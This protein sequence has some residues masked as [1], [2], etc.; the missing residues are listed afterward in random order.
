MGAAADVKGIKLVTAVLDGASVNEIRAMC[1][2]VKTEPCAVAVICAVNSEKTGA[3]FACACSD[4]AVSRGAHA[5]N[6]IRAVSLLAGGSGG[7]KPDSAMAGTKNIEAVDKAMA[8]VESI[9]AD[10]I[11]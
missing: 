7:G 6:I 2:S 3:N 11:K 10:M 9:L 8:A 4:K 1:D 5:G